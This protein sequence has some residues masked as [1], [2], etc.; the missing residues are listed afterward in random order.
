MGRNCIHPGPGVRDVFLTPIMEVTVQHI[1]F[2]HFLM[3][4]LLPWGFSNAKIWPKRTD[5]NNEQFRNTDTHHTHSPVL[6]SQDCRF[7]RSAWESQM[8]PQI[9]CPWFCRTSRRALRTAEPD[10]KMQIEC[11]IDKSQTQIEN[12]PTAKDRSTILNLEGLALIYSIVRNSL[13]FSVMGEWKSKSFFKHDI[14]CSG[15]KAELLNWEAGRILWPE[16]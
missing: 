9:L 13:D 11:F 5:V 2:S 1:H 15:D 14:V 3:H 10:L 16:E 6:D 8:S 12:F 7:Q 4:T